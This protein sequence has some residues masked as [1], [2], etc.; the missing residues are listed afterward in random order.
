MK[1]FLTHRTGSPEDVLLHQHLLSELKKLGVTAISGTDFKK[2]EFGDS[3]FQ[4][5]DAVI[6]DASSE[7]SEIGYMLAIALAHK[8]PVLYLLRKGSLLDASVDSLSKN[9]EVKKLLHVVFYASDSFVRKVK[10]FL[11]YLDQNLGKESFSIKFTLR[12]SPRIDRYL[13][14]KA[15]KADKNKA[16]FLR[17]WVNDLMQSDEEFKKRLQ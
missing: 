14:W 13:N 2:G 11:Q 5:L 1:I 17:D 6:I 10:S 7:T 9:G 8:K 16:D 3:G 12:L 4:S 15:G